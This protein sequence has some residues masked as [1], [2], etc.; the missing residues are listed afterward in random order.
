MRA[1]LSV[2]G[3]V[4]AVVLPFSASY[5]AESAA[6]E[7]IVVLFD[8]G[9]MNHVNGLGVTVAENADDFELSMSADTTSARI[10]ITDIDSMSFPE[11]WDGLVKWFIYTDNAGLPGT[12]LMAGTGRDTSYVLE[13][14]F[15]PY[16]FYW[17]SF[18]LN[19]QVTLDVGV[20]YWFAINLNR[21][22]TTTA[23][24]GWAAS[25]DLNYSPGA[26][27]NPYGSGVYEPWVL[28]FSFVLS[29]NTE[30]NYLFAD[31]FETGDFQFWSSHQP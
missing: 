15:P 24:I 6:P 21:S 26:F 2:V 22:L 30:V 3:L 18:N 10:G 20:R 31:G 13:S 7:A 1:F 19:R 14:S 4:G 9:P 28:D 25:T 5:S 17:L 16:E 12:L 23:G 8:N 11:N 27:N 29:S